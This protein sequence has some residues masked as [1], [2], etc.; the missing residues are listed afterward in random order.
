M[1]PLALSQMAMYS[2]ESSP[3]LLSS[4]SGLAAHARANDAA[5]LSLARARAPAVRAGLELRRRSDADM[6]VS[7]SQP[8]RLA[9]SSTPSWSSVVAT[10]AAFSFVAA[11]AH[12]ASVRAA[13]RAA[14]SRRRDRKHGSEGLTVRRS[15][16]G[17]SQAQSRSTSKTALSGG[18]ASGGAAVVAAEPQAGSVAALLNA[19]SCFTMDVSK[20][21]PQKALDRHKGACGEAPEVHIM[22]VG[23]NGIFA[24]WGTLRVAEP[25]ASLYRRLTDP[26]E[27]L[28]IFSRT[29]TSLN[30]RNLIDENEAESTRLYEVS[31]SGRWKLLGIP[32]SF[33]STVYALEDW[34]NFEIRF[35]LKKQGA[36]KHLSGFWR[37]VPSG[38]RESIVQFYNEASPSV[39][40]PAIFKVFVQRFMQEMASSLLQDLR[41]AAETFGA[42]GFTGDENLQREWSPAATLDSRIDAALSGM[43]SR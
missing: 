26:Q 11:S 1:A 4:E 36:M 38:P 39:S 17:I 35:R 10:T 7:E 30:Y 15:T 24:A 43:S 2:S 25:A 19:I 3:L 18:A 28:R 22:E 8:S 42:G 32:Y 12:R 14:K 9:S 34:E 29:A 27:N 23:A 31:K 41:T 33:E 40:V 20:I 37:V 16:L 5:F 6:H 21:T 13:R